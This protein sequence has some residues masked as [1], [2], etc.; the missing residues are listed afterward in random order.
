MLL[1]V[2]SLCQSIGTNAHQRASHRKIK[3]KETQI[4]TIKSG[5][6]P[7]STKLEVINHLLPWMEEI[8]FKPVRD[9][10]QVPAFKLVACRFY[11]D[12]FGFIAPTNAP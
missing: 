9:E 5:V 8:H 11:T 2:F 6:M 7:S 12:L 3:S 10:R 1:I 4:F